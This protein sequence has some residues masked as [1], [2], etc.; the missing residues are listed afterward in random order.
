MAELNGALVSPDA[1]Q[2]LGLVNYGH[3]TSMRVE[4]QRIRGLSHH[5]DRLVRD[6]RLIFA[7]ELD[8]ER[9][10]DYVRHALRDV[11]ASIIVRVTVFD[12][13]L[14]L[15]HPGGVAH[16]HVLVTTRPAAPLPP[17]P[18][19]VQTVGYERDLPAVKHVGLFG[20]MLGRR[21]AQLARFD[22]ALFVDSTSFITEGATW[23]IGFYDGERVVW[24][25]GDILM[26]VTMRLLQQVHDR[27][28]TVPVNI[29]DIPRMQAAFA[30]NTSIGVRPITGIDDTALPGDHPIFEILRKEYEEIPAETI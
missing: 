27:T 24:P 21:K 23:N 3:F 14:E 13:D 9:V 5:L 25:S 17:S 18:M 19:R 7:A 26:G 11:Q 1:L 16:P 15:G 2:A 30:T 10:R 29:G 20:A 6:C 12:P 4:G 8:R 28:V 22:D